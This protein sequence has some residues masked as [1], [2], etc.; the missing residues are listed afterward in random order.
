MDKNEAKAV[1][2][3]IPTKNSQ[4][5]Y[6]DLNKDSGNE[7]THHLL[8]NVRYDLFPERSWG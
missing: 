7:K 2:G 5:F 3:K 6:N 1:S 8:F 4:H